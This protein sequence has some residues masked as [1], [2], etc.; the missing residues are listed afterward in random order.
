MLDPLDAEALGPFLDDETRQA[1]MAGHVRG[2]AT[3]LV[4]RRE[5]RH[6][7]GDAALA[8]EP[9]RAVDDPVVAVAPRPRPGCRRVTA[10]LGF[11]QCEGDQRPPGGEIR[12][13]ALLL[14]VVAGEQ[15]GQRAQLLDREDQAA[16][17]ARPADLL[18]READVQ[19]RAPEPSVGLGKRQPE[20]VMGREQLLDVPREFGGPVDL[21]GARRY[22]FV[23]EDADRVAEH[24]L[25]LG[26]A[27]GPGVVSG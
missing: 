26:Q 9:L 13:P 25:L 21:R 8:D 4:R 3:G 10:G 20:D 12:E 11:G 7:V 18:D 19:Q 27:V 1:A 16:R 14:V 2:V 15:E 6:E 22:L 23:G 17:R 5:D 24:Q